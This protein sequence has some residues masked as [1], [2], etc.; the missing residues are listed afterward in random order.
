MPC[1]GPNYNPNPPREWYRFENQCAYSNT[2]LN[3]RNG[4]AYQL[5]VLKKGNILQYKKNSANLTKRQRYA[6]IARGLWTNNKITWATQSQTYTNPNIGSLKRVGYYNINIGRTPLLFNLNGR[7]V[8][9]INNGVFFSFQQTYQ[10]LTCPEPQFNNLNYGLPVRPIVYDGV[11]PVVPPIS[12]PPI[13]PNKEIVLSPE[14]PSSGSNVYNNNINNQIP[15]PDTDV[16]PDGGTLICNISENICTGQVYKIT[17]TRNKCSP[18]TDSDV[19]GPITSLCYDESLP[20]YYPRRRYTYSAGGNKWPEG[21]K[22]LFSAN[23]RRAIND[24]VLN[25]LL[26]LN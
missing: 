1:L 20:T 14:I 21:E 16:I 22:F 17:P 19:P 6:Q 4:G 9:A 3:F 10:P 12:N 7:S 15:P 26:L 2:P 24:P 5:E 8:N 11:T 25:G 13:D 18:T 23:S